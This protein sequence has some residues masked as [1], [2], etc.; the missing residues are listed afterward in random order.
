MRLGGSRAQPESIGEIFA[1]QNI[2]VEIHVGIDDRQLAGMALHDLKHQP[3]LFQGIGLG[4]LGLAARMV[5]PFEI[6]HRRQGAGIGRHVLGEPCRLLGG[7]R[8]PGHEVIG[9]T[10]HAGIAGANPVPLE[11]GIDIVFPLGCLH[12][13]EMDAGAARLGEI[14]ILLIAGHVDALDRHGAGAVDLGMGAIVAGYGAIKT[15]ATG[16]GGQSREGQAQNG[17]TNN[18]GDGA[19]KGNRHGQKARYQRTTMSL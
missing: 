15:P 1:G 16:A 14:D 4:R 8:A 3:D 13:H 6:K 19:G 12:E 10:R 18:G 9:A 2:A 7:Q 11:I 17:A 5:V